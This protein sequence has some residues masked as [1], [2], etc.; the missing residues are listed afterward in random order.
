[1]YSMIKLVN[2]KILLIN[3]K[4][5]NTKNTINKKYIYKRHYRHV[6]FCL[7]IELPMSNKLNH[8]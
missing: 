4:V 8:K 5:K 6:L 1:M 3:T 7:L 2:Y